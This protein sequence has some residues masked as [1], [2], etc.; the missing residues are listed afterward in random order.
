MNNSNGLGKIN[1][2]QA[3]KNTSLGEHN[4][5][6]IRKE[7]A[8]KIQYTQPYYATNKTVKNCETDF[9]NFPYSRWYRGVASSVDPI[10]IERESGYRKVLPTLTEEQKQNMS[11]RYNS[12]NTFKEDKGGKQILAL[13]G[14][15]D[16]DNPLVAGLDH[17]YEAACSTVYPCKSDLNSFDYKEAKIAIKNDRNIV[18]SP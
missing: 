14:L 13:N 16:A 11:F 10:I 4:V 6:H 1:T 7:M 17:C 3:S 9:D 12:V 5:S 8:Y 15:Y 2:T 18:I